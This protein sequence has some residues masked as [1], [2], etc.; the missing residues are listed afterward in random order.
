MSGTENKMSFLLQFSPKMYY[1]FTGGV[2]FA[3]LLA[4]PL[5]K[6]NY[7]THI[8]I[9]IFLLAYL[10]QAWNIMCGN[11][12]QLSFGHAAFFGI[13]LYTSSVLFVKLGVSPWAGMFVGGSLAFVV[14][15]VV[16]KVSF[17]YGLKGVYFA[18]VTLTF[19]EMLGLFC[20]LF[21]SLTG[22]AEGILLPWKGHN[23]LMFSFEAN[24]KYLYYYT[25]LAMVLG[26]T[27]VAHWVKKVRFGYYLAAIRENEDAAEMLG[28]DTANYKLVAIAISAF[29]TALGGTFYMQY[30][31]HVE[32]TEAFG[33]FR[34]FEI[35]YPV[36]I[37][38]GGS[39]LGP[40]LGAFV[41]Q[42][43]EEITRA[44]IPPLMHGFHRM[45][46]GVIIVVMIMYMPRGLV[47]LIESCKERLVLKYKIGT[48]E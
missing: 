33:A 10:G 3:I 17:S 28:I 42:L 14:G 16:G 43:F 23:P 30:Y 2:V 41:L 47:G 22:G 29:L 6:N 15:A 18:F 32:P 37:G 11:T 13:G 24:K 9:E 12:G 4:I 35:V 45:I 26:C 44:T 39:I 38:G 36:I 21:K 46:Y 27:L 40:L 19:A 5:L 34:S 25:V 7:I 1:C 8:I 20:L 48:R 31:Q